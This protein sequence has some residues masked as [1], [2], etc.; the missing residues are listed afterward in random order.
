MAMADGV[1][2][3]TSAEVGH[4]RAR[5]GMEE[6]RGEVAQLGGQ[7]IEVGRRGLAG[8]TSGG[9]FAR[10]CSLELGSSCTEEEKGGL[11]R[12][13]KLRGRPRG[14]ERRSD[15]MADAWKRRRRAQSPVWRR[16]VTVTSTV[17][18]LF[19]RLN[20]FSSSLTS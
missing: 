9:G 8:A 4:G 7:W 18:T 16:G 15:A 3:L 10:F 17:E 20:D 2:G 12:H 1:W 11:G 13:Q 14:E 5:G 6:L 19:T